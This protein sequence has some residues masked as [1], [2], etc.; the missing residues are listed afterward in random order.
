[1]HLAQQRIKQVFLGRIKQ[2]ER[3]F[4]NADAVCQL[5]DR[6]LARALLFDKAASAFQQLSGQNR[7]FL[8]SKRNWH[9]LPPCDSFFNPVTAWLE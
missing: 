1:M 5:F 6:D 7:A 9:V 8:R 4:G 2:V 3:S